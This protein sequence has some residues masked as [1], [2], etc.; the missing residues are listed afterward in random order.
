MFLATEIYHTLVSKLSHPAYTPYPTQSHET[1]SGPPYCSKTQLTSSISTSISLL[2]S[3]SILT[4]TN[5]H[6]YMYIHISMLCL[7][8]VY[9]ASL[10]AQLIKESTCNAG[11]PALIPGLGKSP[12]ERIGY[13]LQYSWAFLVVQMIKNLPAMQKTWLR[14]LSWE[15]PLEEGMATHSSILAWRIP[16]DGGAWWATVHR[17]TKSRTQLSS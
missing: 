10:V 2:V 17:V 4:H 8:H 5:L 13:P 6:S 11:D 12:G 15:D 14:S 7:C 3:I 9:G 1:H 16:M